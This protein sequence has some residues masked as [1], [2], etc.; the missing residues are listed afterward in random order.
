MTFPRTPKI[1]SLLLLQWNLSENRLLDSEMNWLRVRLQSRLAGRGFCNQYFSSRM[2]ALLATKTR[3]NIDVQLEEFYLES[4]KHDDFFKVK[5]LVTLPDC[6]KANMHLGHKRD[7]WNDGF[8]EYVF[9]NRLDVSNHIIEIWK[10][11]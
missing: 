6:F 11:L 4:L 3:S 1:M 8:N 5:S 9:G 10:L 2:L 7:C